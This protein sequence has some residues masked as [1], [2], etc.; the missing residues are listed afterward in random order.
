MMKIMIVEDN[1]LIAFNLSK[2][3]KQF[4]DYDILTYDSGEEAIR[5]FDNDSP[6]VVFM[7]IKLAGDL[8][9]IS[10]ANIL[11]Q[12][13]RVPIVFL[14]DYADPEVMRR[15]SYLEVVNFLMKPFD[16]ALI[17]KSLDKALSIVENSTV[18]TKK[19]M[20]N[21]NDLFIHEKE[22]RFKKLSLNDIIYLEADGSYCTIHCLE[23]TISSIPKNMKTIYENV[24]KAASSPE[25]FVKVHKSYVINTDCVNYIQGN[26]LVLKNGHKVDIGKTYRPLIKEIFNI[27]S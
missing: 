15:V 21:T 19:V 20:E 18:S 1:P 6:N 23:E 10:T 14:T 25:K 27:V 24:I 3:I 8:D 22:G 4:G 26:Q 16:D 17:I 11:Q 12:K 9:G 13:T 5:N 7:D 2:S